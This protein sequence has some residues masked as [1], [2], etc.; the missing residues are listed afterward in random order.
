MKTPT[1]RVDHAEARQGKHGGAI[2]SER[3]A[4][5]DLM[6]GFQGGSRLDRVQRAGAHDMG[7][8][9]NGAS[10]ISKS[11]SGPHCHLDGPASAKGLSN[12]KLGTGSDSLK[13]AAASIPSGAKAPQANWGAMKRK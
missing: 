8:V 1:A 10:K 9:I 13:D 6:P 7:S 11:P 4:T 3:G 2:R 5:P 12:G